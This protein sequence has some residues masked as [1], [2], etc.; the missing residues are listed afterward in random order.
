M[1]G[2][3]VAMGAINAASTFLPVFVA[4][5]GG[6]AFEVG[7]L[8]AIPAVCAVLLAIP[9]GQILQR[10]D[11]I[12]AWYSRAR[13]LAHL[14]YAL[15]AAAVLVLPV[16]LAVAAVLVI[17]AAAAV[18]ATIGIVAFPVVMDGAA[19]PRGRLEMMSRRWSIMGVT[20]AIVV[21]LIG[22]ILDRSPF[23]E[24]YALVFVGF[25][26]AGF[27]SWRFSRQY[28]VPR[29]GSGAPADPLGARLRA[30][31]GIVRAHPAFLEFSARQL[32]Y[33]A[34]VRLTLP[35][36][37]LYLVR[38][39]DAPDAWI[40]II[41]TAQSLSLL[42]GYILWRRQARRRGRA[43]MLLITLGMSSLYPLALSLTGSL[44]VV[45]VLAAAASL[46]TAGVDLALFDE[47]M[48][49]IPR[50]YGVTFT[51]MDTTF[52]NAATIIAPLVGAAIAETIGI[53]GAL[54]AGTLVMLCGFVLF[55]VDIRRRHARAAHA[56][57]DRPPDG[58]LVS[59]RQTPGG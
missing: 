50:Q 25:T 38:E 56:V 6:S 8:T 23:P 30:M 22:L 34:G 15:M 5:L 45:A 16:H 10:R 29:H 17:W 14:S 9:A 55:A 32:V 39:L 7:L 3:S 33:V 28:R 26:L 13:W 47:L 37:P 46:F 49:R 51:S 43:F 4:R 19:G 44:A 20:S 40:G 12:V 35:L 59:P 57:V 52:A 53:H 54:R 31:V 41:A 42:V 27:A 24:G 21:S 48:D 11:D 18:P 2:D 58:S 36:I 1:R